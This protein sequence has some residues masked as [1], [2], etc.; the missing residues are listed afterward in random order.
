MQILQCLLTALWCALPRA[1]GENGTSTTKSPLSH[2]DQKFFKKPKTNLS[3]KTICGYHFPA[4]SKYS[5]VRLCTPAL[6][7]I[8][9][10][11]FTINYQ[12]KL[13]A[14]GEKMIHPLSAIVQVDGSQQPDV[15]RHF[16]AL[17]AQSSIPL[18]KWV[19]ITQI[20][21]AKTGKTAVYVNGVAGMTK[22]T[23]WTK[24]IKFKFGF[25][26][27]QFIQK[28]IQPKLENRLSG[29]ISRFQIWNRV[30]RG[31]ELYGL[32]SGYLRLPYLKQPIATL[33]DL[34]DYAAATNG[35]SVV[36]EGSPNCYTYQGTRTQTTGR[37]RGWI[38]HWMDST[39]SGVSKIVVI[40]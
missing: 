19:Q 28:N 17:I 38:D 20:W 18:N 9:F 24:P 26:L 31:A 27:G 1:T 36:Y 30:L 34:D 29:Y 39:N 22:Q 10:E 16:A 4:G 40:Q 2:I 6:S 35:A 12:F 25:F 37:C 11:E 14:K 15:S 23:T 21:S 33:N 13:E 7:D 8:S 5:L 32:R 3:N